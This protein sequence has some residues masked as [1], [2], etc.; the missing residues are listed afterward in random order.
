MEIRGKTALVTGGA[1]R[2][3]KAIT[4][5]LAQGGA[6]VI[7]NYH[8]SSQEAQATAAEARS[9][10]VQALPFQAD[11]SDPEQVKAMVSTAQAELGPVQILVNSASSFARTPFPTP[12]LAAWHH[13]TGVLLDGAFSCANLLAPVMLAQGEGVIINIVDLSVWQPWHNFTAHSVG[14]AGL[15]ALTRQLALELAPSVRVNAVAPGLVLPPPDYDENKIARAA[16]RTLLKRWGK[17]KDVADA[18][19]FLIRSDFITGEVIVVDGG[20]RYASHGSIKTG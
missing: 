6:D 3:G 9:M 12:D 13:V 16:E 11:I 5:A 4:L 2:V 20:E 18:V 15:M 10:N 8:H 17:P 1:R 19:I 14:K 7:I